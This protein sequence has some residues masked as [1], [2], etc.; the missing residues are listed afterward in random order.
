M[1]T[2]VIPIHSLGLVKQPIHPA[3]IIASPIVDAQHIHRYG[4]QLVNLAVSVAILLQA[5]QL[6][7][8]VELERVSL[9]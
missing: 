1:L 3:F 4:E 7:V 6:L 2:R 9:H 8:L 5:H